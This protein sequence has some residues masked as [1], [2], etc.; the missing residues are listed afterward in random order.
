MDDLYTHIEVVIVHIGRCSMYNIPCWQYTLFIQKHSNCYSI[1][2]D[3]R[4]GQ[5]TPHRSPDWITSSET[6]N[7]IPPSCAAVDDSILLGIFDD[8]LISTNNL[9]H[10]MM[11]HKVT[12]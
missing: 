4:S 8:V 1:V 7:A 9:S 11:S 5:G 10:E 6:A 12:E 3:L 2:S